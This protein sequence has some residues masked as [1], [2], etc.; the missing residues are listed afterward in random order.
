MSS[1]NILRI[2][3]LGAFLNIVLCL[4]MFNLLGRWLTPQPLG[5]SKGKSPNAHSFFFGKSRPVAF[6]QTHRSDK[7]AKPFRYESELNT[8]NLVGDNS[9][10]K[11]LSVH[12]QLLKV[13]N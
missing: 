6:V 3:L 8:C 1:R 11:I 9:W 12:D 10:T 4:T 5:V 13:V 2:E 7:L